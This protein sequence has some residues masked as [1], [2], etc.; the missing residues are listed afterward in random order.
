MSHDCDSL[1]FR[2]LPARVE[3]RGCVL[4]RIGRGRFCEA[5]RDISSPSRVILRVRSEDASKEILSRLDFAG[6][7]R[8]QKL[9]Q[10]DS[11]T[12]VWE[13]EW[14]EP[15]SARKTPLAWR[16]YR[17]FL[18]AWEAARWDGLAA[19]GVPAEQVVALWTAFAGHLRDFGLTEWA[20]AFD[21]LFYETNNYGVYAVEIARRNA[22]VRVEGGAE[23]LVLT[24][25]IFDFK[26]VA[27]ENARRRN[28]WRKP[29]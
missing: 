12:Y 20:T 8:L 15:L 11:G 23:R 22:R 26:Q 17:M 9:G 21:D 10:E 14:L 1:W 19:G 25:P 4:E 28:A 5:F 24:D 13:T 16:E 18:G 2:R 7:P 3:F 6:F 29:T 27:R